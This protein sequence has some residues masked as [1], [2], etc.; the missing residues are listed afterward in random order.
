VG[1]ISVKIPGHF[2][3][4]I[5]SL[6]SETAWGDVQKYIAPD[7]AWNTRNSET[8]ELNALIE[9]AQ[10]APL[11]D[12]APFHAITEYL[13]ENAWFAPWYAYDSV[14]MTNDEVDVTMPSLNV[15]PWLWDYR[16]KQ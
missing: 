6:G 14:Y 10:Y 11:D 15:V 16:P 7:A 9:S 1:Q 3:A 2:S 13:V 12:D 8:E 4:E 5:N